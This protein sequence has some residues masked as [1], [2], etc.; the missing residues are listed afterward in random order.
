MIRV[1]DPK[2]SDVPMG[3]RVRVSAGNYTHEM[4]QRTYMPGSVRVPTDQP[5]GALAQRM[6]EPRGE[7]SLFQ[8]VFFMGMLTRTEYIEGYVIEPL[9]RQ[10]MERDPSLK[11]AFEAKLQRDPA[12][13]GDPN[14]RLAWFYER[15]PY[16]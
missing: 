6:L 15:T 4:Q 5:L 11:K 16:Y 10:M 2:L 7:D 9:A 1:H 3:V 13:A 8:W 12:F 14:A